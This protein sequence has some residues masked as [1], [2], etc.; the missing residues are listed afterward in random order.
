[1]PHSPV[2]V[3][4]GVA[5]MATF[6][7]TSSSFILPANFS[8]F[9]GRCENDQIVL[10][11]STANEMNNNYFTIEKNTADNSWLSVGTVQSKGNASTRQDYSFSPDENA[12]G[13]SYFRLRQTDIDGRFTYSET[14]AVNACGSPKKISRFI[15]TLPRHHAVGKNKFQIKPALVNR[16][17]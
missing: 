9:T 15:Q 8:S 10:H 2:R 13:M 14:I 12:D 6:I 5:Q 17:V 7:S 4:T 16:G 1:M 3:V 11:W